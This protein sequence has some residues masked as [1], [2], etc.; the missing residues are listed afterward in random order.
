MVKSKRQTRRS[1]SSKQFRGTKV[2]NLYEKFRGMNFFRKYGPGITECEIYKILKKKRIHESDI[3]KLN[4]KKSE[5][6]IL[7]F[8]V[9]LE[10]WISNPNKFLVLTK[11][12]QWPLQFWFDTLS[13]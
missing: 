7:L 13:L 3:L 11:H 8:E 10:Q 5:K 12:L 9:K 4:S 1:G 2:T 6:Y